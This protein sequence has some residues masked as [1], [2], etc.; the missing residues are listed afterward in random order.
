MLDFTQ[1]LLDREAGASRNVAS[2]CAQAR[3]GYLSA[4]LVNFILIAFPALSP[5]SGSA[6]PRVKIRNNHFINS[7]TGETFT[8]RGFNYV[9]LRPTNG[10]QVV[11]ANFDPAYY[12]VPEIEAMFQDLE[13]NNFNVVRVF[14]DVTYPLGLFET[15]IATR[16]SPPYT[17]NVIDFLQRAS[18]HD[19]YVILAFDMWGPPADSWLHHGPHSQAKVTGFN[20]LYFRE[21]AAETRAALL[22]EYAAAIKNSAPE[23]LPAVFSYEIQNE[24]CYFMDYEPLSLTNGTFNYNGDDFDLSSEKEIQDLMDAQAIN[25][26]NHCVTEVKKIDS[27]AYVSVSVF[28][29]NAVGR[30]GSVYLKSDTTSDDRVPARPLAL[31]MSKLDF[32]D[33]HVYPH[34]TNSVQKDFQSIDFGEVIKDCPR[35]GKPLLLGE[36]GAFKNNFPTL[37]E[38]VNEVS[39]FAKKSF[40]RSF[41]GWAY[42]TY[43]TDE[44]D[45]LWNGKSQNG[46]I[47]TALAEVTNSIKNYELYLAD[48]FDVTGSGNI[49]FDISGGRQ[50]G[51]LAPLSYTLGSGQT[52]VTDYGSF[53]GKCRMQ[54]TTTVS[55]NENLTNSFV[56]ELEISV[57]TENTGA[58]TGVCF[59]KGAPLWEPW[60][61]TGMSIIFRDN[62]YY[63]FFDNNTPKAELP[64]S[65]NPFVKLKICVTQSGLGQEALV[66]IFLNGSPV[67]LD[68]SINSTVFNHEGGFTNNFITIMTFSDAA[69]AVI[70]NLKISTSQ[71]TGPEISPW[72]GDSDSGI[73]NSKFYTHAINFTTDYDVNVYSVIFEGVGTATAGT[74]WALASPSNSFA[75]IYLNQEALPNNL[76]GGSF[77]LGTGAVYSTDFSSSLI[78]SN[79]NPAGMYELTLFGVGF[80]TNN[81]VYLSGSDGGQIRDFGMA[82]YGLGNGQKIKYEYI[83]DTNGTFSI[84]S[85]SIAG[86]GTNVWAW[87]AFS[88]EILDGIPEPVFP[89]IFAMIFLAFFINIK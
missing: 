22:S 47:L 15:N 74:G 81:L 23:L 42:W 17:T 14:L 53:A 4:I 70:D 75:N 31:T 82:R 60:K 44:Q 65:Q 33:I 84:S 54:S 10:N 7:D 51:T 8:P 67:V 55:I 80:D 66:S 25:L 24:L 62:G 43:D 6:L 2:K 13:T 39:E 37:P 78:L 79:L 72:T 11:H 9:R 16:F 49:N 12:N 21:G 59:G 87:F 1:K 34:T 76:S 28:T 3:S 52:T 64:Y 56:I 88:N 58:W 40:D 5:L 41:D 29:F 45:R 38:A 46:E 83:P 85:S 32:V 73:T 69:D 71:D 86:S 68:T 63:T 35:T 26:C 30:T 19:I 50:S 20:W 18:N 89:L 61:P 57:N 36:F 48:D 27:E 77:S